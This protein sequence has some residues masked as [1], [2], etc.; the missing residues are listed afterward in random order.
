MIGNKIKEEPV[1]PIAETSNGDN[2]I[3]LKLL[4][5]I[6]T[7]GAVLYF[8]GPIAAVTARELYTQYYAAR[9]GL[10][11]VYNPNYW[12][13]FMPLREHAGAYAYSYG[14]TLLTTLGTVAVKA[15][16]TIK[17]VKGK[18]TKLNDY[19]N[20]VKKE[21]PIKEEKPDLISVKIEKT[22][23]PTVSPVTNPSVEIDEELDK[24]MK[25]FELLSLSDQEDK[26]TTETSMEIDEENLGIAWLF[27]NDKH[28]EIKH[29]VQQ[30]G[31]TPVVTLKGS[32]PVTA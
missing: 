20:P 16:D 29:E 24:L 30:L 14:P 3:S 13:T 31:V 5:G 1:A 17:W 22:D 6:A 4:V 32:A 12:L 21:E 9:Y 25:Q 7:A 19:F 11:A 18:A 28:S 2:L 27:D 23:E 8:G 15:S 26:P 10:P